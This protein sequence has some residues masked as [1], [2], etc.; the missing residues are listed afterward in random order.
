[1]PE[2][3]WGARARGGERRVAGQRRGRAWL[4]GGTTAR[5]TISVDPDV[6]AAYGAA[7]GQDRRTLELLA[8][9]RLRDVP[10]SGESL[11]DVVEE[12]RRDGQKRGLTREIP[13]YILEGDDRCPE[14]A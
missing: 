14:G 5:I 10:G 6:V 11:R 2:E 3:V 7:S 12:I 4:L 13:R 8:N 9:P 1:M